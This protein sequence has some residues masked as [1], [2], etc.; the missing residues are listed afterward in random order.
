MITAPTDTVFSDTTPTFEFTGGATYEC[1]LG[2]TLF[3]ACQSGIT[4]GPLND[5]DYRF[6]VRAIA[7]DGLPQQGSTPFFFRVDTTAPDPPTIDEPM[8][9]TVIARRT[10]ELRGATEDFTEVDVYDG[11]PSRRGR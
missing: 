9:G 1:R 2:D 3:T 4:Y 7:A 10:L 6:D 11:T 5:G 8:D